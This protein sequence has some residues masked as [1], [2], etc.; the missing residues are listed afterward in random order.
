[1]EETMGRQ[2]WTCWREMNRYGE[3]STKGWEWEVVHFKGTVAR[4]FCPLFF[5]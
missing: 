1:M 4:Y 2:G 5:S 3:R